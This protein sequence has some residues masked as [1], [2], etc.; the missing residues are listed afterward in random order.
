MRSVQVEYYFIDLEL[1]RYY[2]LV[3]SQA[4]LDLSWTESSWVKPSLLSDLTQIFPHSIGKKN[5]HP[6]F[7]SPC[8]GKL[9]LTTFILRQKNDL[10]LQCSRYIE[11]IM[12]GYHSNIYYKYFIVKNKDWSISLPFSIHKM[13]K[14]CISVKSFEKLPN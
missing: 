3:L 7:S 6:D 9:Y 2:Y 14:K 12:L 10:K 8:Q 5:V 4:E 1:R 11:F 13:K